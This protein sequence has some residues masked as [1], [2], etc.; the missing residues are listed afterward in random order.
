MIIIRDDWTLDVPEEEKAI[1]YA[2]EN[3]VE[4][5]VFVLPAG[6]GTEW[7]YRLDLRL[8]DG[9]TDIVLLSPED[10]TLTWEIADRHLKQSSVGRGEVYAQIRADNGDRVKKSAVVRFMVAASIDAPATTEINPSEIAQAEQRMNALLLDGQAA[11]DGAEDAAA[12]AEAAKQDAIRQAE[13]AGDAAA[14]ALAAE[15]GA[16]KERAAAEE[17]AK[18]TAAD[19]L[20]TG[21]D[22]AEVEQLAGQV[23]ADQEQVGKDKD[24]VAGD[25]TAAETAKTGAE[26]AEAEAVKQ[27]EISKSKADEVT[28]AVG[29]F[30][31][32][33]LPDAVEQVTD[34][35]AAQVVL[36][37]EQAE[38]AKTEAD[39]AAGIDAYTKNDADDRYA[40]VLTGAASGAVAALEDV[41]PTGA[42]RRAAVLGATTETGTG[43]KGPDN[44][45]ALTGVQ[46]TSLTVCGRNMI[47]NWMQGMIST[48]DG[49]T[50]TSNAYWVYAQDFIPISGNEIVSVDAVCRAAIYFYD[51]VKGYIGEI[52]PFMSA[53]L[54]YSLANYADYGKAKYVRIAYNFNGAQETITPD[55]MGVKHFVQLEK[56]DTATPYEPYTGQTITLPAL[57][58]L[59]GDGTVND[60]YDAVSGVETRRWGILTPDGT[61]ATYNANNGDAYFNLPVSPPSVAGNTWGQSDKGISTHV[62]FSFTPKNTARAYFASAG[63]RLYIFLGP[64]HADIDTADKLQTWLAAQAAAG[65]PFTVVYQLAEPV[66]TQHDPA[67][68]LPPAPVCRVFADA[69]N[70]AVGYN[71]DVNI[72]FEQQRLEYIEQITALDARVAQLEISAPAEPMT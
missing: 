39:R 51:S 44:P 41:S 57:E 4:R 63:K 25:K 8:A 64:E 59:Y 30:T 54:P 19:R 65:T 47:G 15:Q 70:T 7:V 21:Q 1:G 22:R 14:G 62:P 11:R 32:T 61:G 27:A 38:R 10:G 6:Y 66:V 2:G 28:A 18:Q 50:I 69:G 35:G 29:E 42:L 13:L 53:N 52:Q 3:E 24:T 12:L 17:A 31:G 43:G 37:T 20:A 48:E 16:A 5:R 9:S 40:N 49:N 68:I 46:P 72:A 23:R 56:G 55:E 34:A 33:T 36:A 45:Y 60:E 71:R 26:A 58:P 67:R